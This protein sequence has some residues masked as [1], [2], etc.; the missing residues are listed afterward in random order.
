MALRSSE[1]NNKYPSSTLLRFLIVLVSTY[2]LFPASHV[3][4]PKNEDSKVS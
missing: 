4:R 1:D 2:N 3:G